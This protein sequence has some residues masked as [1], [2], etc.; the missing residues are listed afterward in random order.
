MPRIF[1]FASMFGLAAFS[2]AR[3]TDPTP[4]LAATAVPTRRDAMVDVVERVQQSVVN[5]HSKRTMAGGGTDDPFRTFG[6][7][8]PQQVNGMGTG[9]VLD[10]RGY[11]VTNHHVVDD[12]Q[13]LRVTLSDGTNLPAKVLAV[14]K[15]ADLALIKID[16][17]RPLPTVPLGTASDILMAEQVLAIGNAYGYEHTVTVGYISA[18]NRDVT[19]N[20][21][22]SYKALIQT[23]TPINPGNSGGPLFNKFGELVGVNVAIRANS[24][25]IAFAIPVDTM[26]GRAAELLAGRKRSGLRHGMVVQDHVVRDSTDSM[27]KR[28]A[29]V[30]A[31]E[32]NS[33]AAAAGVKPGDRIEQVGD[34]VAKTSL[35]VE[36]GFVEKG[37]GTKVKVKLTRGTGEP[38]VVEL[39]LMP[40][41]TAPG[42][43]T[44]TV[45]RRFGIKTTAVSKS[46]VAAVNP[47]L[48]GGLY[49]EEVT[50]GGPAAVAGL[51][52]GDVL[53][54]V[55]LWESLSPEHV[56][57]VLNQKDYATF[58]PLKIYYVR[59]GKLRDTSLT[60]EN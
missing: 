5:I 16:A 14:D 2:A 47:E 37:A 58:L 23:T 18:K 29:V 1:L 31:V 33:S 19:L 27:V 51:A 48:R 41:V 34:L 30:A 15:E 6:S 39:A 25:N 40:Q 28:W 59:G 32:P 49:L 35:D 12:V 42:T 54:G 46:A 44:E 60:P 9:I 26:I 13:S 22:V 38:V 17:P 10:P 45:H 56:L 24:Q 36:R 21:D 55:H 57:H 53:I 8:Q 52:K 20:K 50:P 4:S 3:A 7:M 43:P 11:V